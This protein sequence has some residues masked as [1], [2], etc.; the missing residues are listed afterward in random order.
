MIRKAG[1]IAADALREAN[2]NAFWAYAN[3]YIAQNGCDT[4]HDRDPQSVFVGKAEYDPR[5][6]T[7]DCGHCA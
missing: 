7:L 5:G 6:F 4:C 2:T 3:A 1:H